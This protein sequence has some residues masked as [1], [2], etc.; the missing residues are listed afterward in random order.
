MDT[1]L[2]FFSDLIL[3]TAGLLVAAFWI[4]IIILVSVEIFDTI[5]GNDSKLF[6]DKKED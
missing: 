4:L 2:N 1:L 6:P 5:T 3:F